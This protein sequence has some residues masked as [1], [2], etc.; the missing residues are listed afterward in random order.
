MLPSAPHVLAGAAFDVLHLSLD[1]LLL[2]LTVMAGVMAV[3]WSLY[4]WVANRSGGS[5]GTRGGYLPVRR[6]DEG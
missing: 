5:A 2:I 3:G 6:S 1:Q 4:A